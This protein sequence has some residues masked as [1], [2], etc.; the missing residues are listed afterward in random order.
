MSRREHYL[1]SW[2]D[3]SRKSSPGDYWLDKPP[4]RGLGKLAN[5]VS[6]GSLLHCI[7]VAHNLQPLTM[8]VMSR[9][10]KGVVK[11]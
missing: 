5:N 4:S 11:V 1:R 6:A 2:F 10:P 7:E 3:H 8:N 9:V